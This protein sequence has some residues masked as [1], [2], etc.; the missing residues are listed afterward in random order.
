MKETGKEIPERI[1]KDDAV[2]AQR[3]SMGVIA[4][5]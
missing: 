1:A 4:K 5:A 2:H 3:F